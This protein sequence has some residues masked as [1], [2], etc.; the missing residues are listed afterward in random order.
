MRRIIHLQHIYNRAKFEFCSLSS[1]R[2]TGRE[3]LPVSQGSKQPS[4][5]RVKKLENFNERSRHSLDHLQ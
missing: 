1:L 3:V 4:S 5:K 2:H